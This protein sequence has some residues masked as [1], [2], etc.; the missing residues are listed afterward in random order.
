MSPITTVIFDMFN[1]L[2]K[3]GESFWLASF[4][5]VIDQQGLDVTAVALRTEWSSGDNAFRAR[6]V[7]ADAQFQSY[8]DAWEASFRRTFAALGL[9]GD[10]T[11]AVD[12]LIADMGQRPLHDDTAATL[13]LLQGQYRLA[14]LSNVDDNVLDTCL[15]RIGCPFEASVSSEAARC[16]KPRPELFRALLVRLDVRPE[17]AVY[18]GDKQ[19]EDVQGAR[20]AGLHSVWINRDNTEAVPSLPAPD[21]RAE[22]LLEVPQWLAGPAQL[23][24]NR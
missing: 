13:G 15:G 20:N 1:T 4:Q 7:S 14:V 22:S 23:S 10:P 6:R 17:Q 5:R 24:A 8:H 18:I 16:Y 19:Y 3:D 12:L 2:V 21:Y 11:E 9:N